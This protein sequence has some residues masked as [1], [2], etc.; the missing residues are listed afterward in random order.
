MSENPMVDHVKQYGGATVLCPK[1]TFKN[2]TPDAQ[3]QVLQTPL[4]GYAV[5]TERDSYALI[6]ES[7][8]SDAA[9]WQAVSTMPK[10]RYIGLWLHEGILYVDE[11]IVVGTLQEATRLGV[12]NNQKA[13]M[14]LVRLEEV[15]IQ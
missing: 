13:V 10:E 5:A 14:D 2:L 6:P 15:F 1:H 3:A 12:A 11:S 4:W 8:M 9:I 7:E